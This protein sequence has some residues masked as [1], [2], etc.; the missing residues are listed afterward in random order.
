MSILR[1]LATKLLGFDI[2]NEDED[3]DEYDGITLSN[4]LFVLDMGVF[5]MVSGYNLTVI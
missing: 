3:D 2:E 4:L 5:E 1:K